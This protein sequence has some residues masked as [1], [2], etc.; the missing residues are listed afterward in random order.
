MGE[1]L[2]WAL[3]CVLIFVVALG[4]SYAMAKGGRR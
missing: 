2:P 3:W 4:V 1:F